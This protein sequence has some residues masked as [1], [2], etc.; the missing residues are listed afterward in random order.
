MTD[1][2]TDMA[3]DPEKATT[4]WQATTTDIDHLRL[5]NRR[6]LSLQIVIDIPYDPRLPAYCEL[7]GFLED[8]DGNAR[9]PGTQFC[10]LTLD[11]AI[12]NQAQIDPNWIEILCI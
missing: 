2:E 9:N 11:L 12:E 6:L 10:Y 3:T 8:E 7:A 4:H 1:C 5:L